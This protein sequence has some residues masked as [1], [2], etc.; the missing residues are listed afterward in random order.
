EK[1]RD[2]AFGS[3]KKAGAAGVVVV[4]GKLGSSQ[5]EAIS[6]ARASACRPAIVHARQGAV[7][8]SE[9]RAPSQH[10][11]HPARDAMSE[12]DIN[13]LAL[14]IHSNRSGIPK[15]LITVNQGDLVLA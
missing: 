10:Q 9:L 3:A 13:D 1:R 5:L 14:K 8:V 15:G 12:K 2:F 11:V 7:H 6:Q 4:V